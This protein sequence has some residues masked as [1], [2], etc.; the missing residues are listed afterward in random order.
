M[1]NTSVDGLRAELAQLLTEH[2]R[3]SAERKRLHDKIDFGFGSDETRARER[4]VSDARQEVHN[5]I[6]A[7]QERIGSV[8]VV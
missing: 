6:N 7:L 2:E 5:R 3:L 1:D 4:E 8:E